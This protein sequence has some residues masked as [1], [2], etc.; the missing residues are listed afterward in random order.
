MKDVNFR[1]PLTLSKNIREIDSFSVDDIC[2]NYSDLNID[3]KRFFKNKN[4]SLYKCIDTGYR[5]YFPYSVVGDAKFYESLSKNRVN[6]YSERWEHRR[7][8]RFINK[9]DYV[10][11]IGSGFGSFLKMLKAR[12][13]KF[14]GLE[15][16]PHAVLTCIDDGLDVEQKLIQELA[17]DNDKRFDA[18]CF[19]QVLEHITEVH[20]FLKSAIKTLKTGGKLI[21]G[22]PNNNPFLFKYDKYHTLN[23]PPHHAGL[24]NKKSL[25]SL[26]NIF[27]LKLEAMLFEPLNENYDYYLKVLLNQSNNI[28]EKNILEVLN[29]VSP[30]LLKKLICKYHKGRNV[31][32]VYLKV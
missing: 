7:A 23:L 19:F 9:D 24:W 27:P 3:V 13:I 2:N 15:L 21:I 10:L 12:N 32:A 18:V 17:I 11:E 28:I 26:E 6:Y 20:D 22:V 5:F 1:S 30:R 31:V 25:S 16:N 29:K 14:K 8:L 4:V